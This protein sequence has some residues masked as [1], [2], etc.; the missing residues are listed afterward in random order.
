VEFAQPDGRIGG[1][2]SHEAIVQEG[3]GKEKPGKRRIPQV[4]CFYL[5]YMQPL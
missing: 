4:I 1:I 3:R 5:L 2:E